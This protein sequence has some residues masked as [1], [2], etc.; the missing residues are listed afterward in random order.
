M[1]DNAKLG[2][3]MYCDTEVD[4]KTAP[5][6]ADILV[7]FK[8]YLAMIT[9]GAHSHFAYGGIASL[10]P[11]ERKKAKEFGMRTVDLVYGP[12]RKAWHPEVPK[13]SLI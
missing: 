8:I 1:P 11:D 9:P 3:E 12:L 6:I 7:D 2:I 4:E 10:D 5:E 13:R